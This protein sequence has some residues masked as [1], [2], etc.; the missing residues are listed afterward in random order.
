MSQGGPKIQFPGDA[1]ELAR[2][3]PGRVAV[4]RGLPALGMGSVA[5]KV[6]GAA[7]GVAM[8]PAA[9][10]ADEFVGADAHDNSHGGV[11]VINKH[12]DKVIFMSVLLEVFVTFRMQRRALF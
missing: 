3:P 5:V 12:D 6:V 1:V 11:D 2:M 10:G 4:G 9:K 7:D 8:A